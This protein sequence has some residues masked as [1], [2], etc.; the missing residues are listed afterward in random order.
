MSFLFG[1]K[2]KKKC[3]MPILNRR[4]WIFFDTPSPHI[5]PYHQFSDPSPLNLAN[6]FYGRP[7]RHNNF[8]T[9]YEVEIQ[10][11]FTTAF[12]KKCQH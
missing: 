2:E 8:Q 4:Y 11:L 5:D 10:C 12:G 9:I 6:V 3:C 7:L 1:E